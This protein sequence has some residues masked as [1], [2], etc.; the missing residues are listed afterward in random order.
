MEGQGN[1]L[2]EHVE[3]VDQD[4]LSEDFQLVHGET[5]CSCYSTPA[6]QNSG[7]YTK[8]LGKSNRHLLDAHLDYFYSCLHL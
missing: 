1:A 8:V 4:T 7:F 6:L 5:C 3:E 2:G